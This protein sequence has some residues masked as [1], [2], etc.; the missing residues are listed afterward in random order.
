ML[1]TTSVICLLVI[2]HAFIACSSTLLGHALQRLHRNHAVPSHHDH[3]QLCVR[4]LVHRSVQ[5]DVGKRIVCSTAFRRREAS[6][7]Q[8]SRVESWFHLCALSLFRSPAL[9]Q[10]HPDTRIQSRIQQRR[11]ATKNAADIPS[12]IHLDGQPLVHQSLEFGREDLHH[13][14]YVC[15]T[16]SI[17]GTYNR[18]EYEKVKKRRKRR[19]RRLREHLIGASEP[20]DNNNKDDN[21]LQIYM[22]VRNSAPTVPAASVPMRVLIAALGA[23]LGGSALS[24]A[25]I[26]PAGYSAVCTLM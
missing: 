7:I 23:G 21:K 14:L 20:L 16:T 24:W 8:V 13:R 1:S 18:C 25:R 26:A 2:G 5:H 15:G 17:C 12:G 22:I 3:P 19:R 4:L 10:Q 11:T 9:P 6:E